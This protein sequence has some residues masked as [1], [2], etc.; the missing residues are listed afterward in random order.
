PAIVAQGDDDIQGASVLVIAPKTKHSIG[1][2]AIAAF[3]TGWQ[4]AYEN[5]ADVASGA[6]KAK[7]SRTD[8][9]NQITF[10]DRKGDIWVYRG[11]HSRKNSI[12]DLDTREMQFYY[13]TLPGFWFPTDID[14]T[15]L[16]ADSQPPI[17][18]ITPYLRAMPDSDPI[19]GSK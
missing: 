1:D 7:V 11:P 3:S 17:G 13:K 10:Q 14:G 16:T 15:A 12:N 5:L 18:T 2:S 4:V 19:Y 9:Y 6:D 8:F